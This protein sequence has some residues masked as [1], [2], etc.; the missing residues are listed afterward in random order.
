MTALALAH[1]NASLNY[2]GSPD[3]VA[4]YVVRYRL[5]GSDLSLTRNGG[6]DFRIGKSCPDAIGSWYDG[7][8]QYENASSDSAKVA[9]GTGGLNISFWVNTTTTLFKA[10]AGNGDGSTSN[11]FRVRQNNLGNVQFSIGGVNYSST[12]SINDGVWHHVS[13]NVSGSGGTLEFYIDGSFD[14]STSIGTYDI[15][16]STRLGVGS[17]GDI[18]FSARYIGG[19][20]D[21]RFY[22]RVLSASEITALYNYNC[23]WNPSLLSGQT[24]YD[25]QDQTTIT[26]ASGEVSQ[27]DDKGLSSINLTQGTGSNQPTTAVS[28]I[29]GLN[30]LDFDTDDYLSNTTLSESFSNAQLVVVAVLN[31]DATR[32]FQHLVR[33]ENSATSDIFMIRENEATTSLQGTVNSGSGNV[34]TNSPANLVY[35]TPFIGRQKYDSVNA[36][37][38][39][40]GTGGSTN[41]ATG[42]IDIDE[43]FISYTANQMN[44]YIGEVVFIPSSDETLGQ[45]IEG[46]LA[47]KWGLVSDLPTGHPYKS[48]PPKI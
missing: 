39:F 40:N 4:D 18:T 14:S 15:Q 31:S 41:S 20:D 44:G 45:K 43:I 7:S 27:W 21:F 42:A 38:F 28:S 10:M 46:Y 17:Q 8:G 5:D 11:D 36:Q 33:L 23:D 37:T 32:A 19:L 47:W 34:F 9:I 12:G 1:K 26:E 2:L 13:I 35:G 29:N 16:D 6:D 25:A 24:W 22:N 3:P 48:A 30:T